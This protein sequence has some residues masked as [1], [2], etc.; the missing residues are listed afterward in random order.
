[1]ELNISYKATNIYDNPVSE[2]IYEFV[3][4]PA[5]N[6]QQI[7]YGVEVENSL[8]K[9]TFKYKNLF[10]FDVIRIRTTD[11]FKEMRVCMNANVYTKVFNPFEFTPPL[12]M[13]TDRIMNELDYYLENHL[14][15]HYTK[16]T[17]LPNDLVNDF[18]KWERGE[19]LFEFLMRMNALLHSSF[20][21]EK[22]VTDVNSAALDFYQLKCGVCQDYAHL[23]IALCRAYR[24]PA[25][26][27]SGYLNQDTDFMGASMM[28]AWV[29]A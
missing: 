17:M 8:Q 7:T 13:L 28:H 29:E 22:G 1:M 12:R 18:I 21:Y 16:F 6:Q 4:L 10:G 5:N 15:L 14:Y 23:F 2:A 11:T 24:I 19:G 9:S 25:R 20:T 26:Y 3:L 27:V